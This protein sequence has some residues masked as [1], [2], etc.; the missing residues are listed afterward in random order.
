MKRLNEE[1]LVRRNQTSLWSRSQCA[2]SFQ[3]WTINSPPTAANTIPV[4]PW[5]SRHPATHT[6]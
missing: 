2:R 6:R 3:S 1:P 4:N 5:C